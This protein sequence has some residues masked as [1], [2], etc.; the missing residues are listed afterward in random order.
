MPN[1][2]F[3]AYG[4]DHRFILEHLFETMPCRIF[5]LASAFDTEITEFRSLSDVERRYQ[6]NDWSQGQHPTLYLQLYAE[7]ADGKV[8]FRRDTLN[9][10][11]ACKGATYRYSCHGWGLIQLYLESPRNGS[12]RHSHT[13]HNS[14]TRARNWATTYTELGDQRTG[15][16]RW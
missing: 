6:I 5:E 8:S 3:F 2:D 15:I 4:D 10:K 12:L 16:G 13:N 9:P 11:A 7:G 1:C 14:E